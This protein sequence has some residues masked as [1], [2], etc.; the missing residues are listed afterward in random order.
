[1]LAASVAH[2]IGNPLNSI[3]LHLQ[4][5][6]RQLLADDVDKVEFADLLN[7]AKSEV[8]RLDTIVHQFLRAMRPSKPN[9]KLVNVQEVLLDSL[10]F[11]KLEIQDRG[12]EIQFIIDDNIPMISG[13]SDQLKQA[14]YNIIKNSIQAML[15]GGVIQISIIYN[16]EEVEVIFADS[17]PGISQDEISN[18][19]KPFHTSKEMGNGLGLL[20]V[21][22][23]IREHNA[24]F[25]VNSIPNKGTAFVLKFPRPDK[26]VKCLEMPEVEKEG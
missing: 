5:M 20:V 12:V 8:E 4:L 11:M 23:I 2:E 18:I 22:R 17:G 13:D 14:F 9:F 26:V 16:D 15:Q 24:E 10:K 7:T 25:A 1:M 6:E 21:E 3:Y 19:F